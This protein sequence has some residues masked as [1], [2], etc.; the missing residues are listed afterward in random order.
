MKKL[1]ITIVNYNAGEFLIKCLETLR[2]LEKEI[3]FDVYVIDNDSK[4]GSIEEAK[5]K[6]TNFIFIDN[7][8]NLGF[9]KAHNIALKLAK[10][11]YLLTLNPDCEI[12]AGTL[13]YIFDYMEKNQDVGVATSKVVKADGSLDIASHRGFPTP[14]ASFMY[15]FLKNDKYY[16]LT[17]QDMN[18]THEIDSAVGAF[19]FM[20]RSV[21]EAVGYFDE[22]YF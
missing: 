14:K 3:D 8:A 19:M 10:T 11:P 12:P 18:K 13:K 7:K 20:R 17:D 6:F 16:H 2:K 15:F 22:D 4:D 5:K 21:L 1:S 9:G